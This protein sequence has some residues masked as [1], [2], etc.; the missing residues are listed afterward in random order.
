[1]FLFFY[2]YIFHMSFQASFLGKDC[3]TN[4]ARTIIDRSR[5]GRS[6]EQNNMKIRDG[7]QSIAIESR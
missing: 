4:V 1:M 2:H 6:I 5:L 7:V 3:G